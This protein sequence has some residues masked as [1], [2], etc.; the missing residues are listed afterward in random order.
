MCGFIGYISNKSDLKN[1]DYENKF[2]KYLIKLKN[3]GPDYT[4]KKKIFAF[5]KILNFGFSRLAI[6]D[7]SEKSNKIFSNNN[8]I[9]LFNGEIYNFL[10]LKRKYF[11]DHKFETNTDTELLFKLFDK[12]GPEKIS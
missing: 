8:K 5:E 4:E 6:Q 7:L 12:F 2:N 3:R 10:E 9:L 11:Y 1:R